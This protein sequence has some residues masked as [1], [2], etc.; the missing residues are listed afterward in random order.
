MKSVI[1]QISAQNRLLENAEREAVKEEIQ[2]P[3]TSDNRR[4]FLKKAALGG[5]G[6][7]PA[8][9]LS[10]EDTISRPLVE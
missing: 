1:D 7:V 5:V 9:I 6:R 8:T 10:I 2:H 3:A 4:D